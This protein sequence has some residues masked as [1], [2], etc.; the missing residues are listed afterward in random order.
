MTSAANTQWSKFTPVERLGRYAVYLFTVAAVA[1]S[2]RS[3]EIIPEFLSDAPAQTADLFKRMWPL[4][5]A[6]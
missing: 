1:W 4:D 6:A 3:I 5:T 2:A